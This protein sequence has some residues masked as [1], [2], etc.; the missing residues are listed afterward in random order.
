MVEMKKEKNKKPNILLSGGPVR[1]VG[2]GV[3]IVL[4]AAAAAAIVA[5]EE[6]NQRRRRHIAS[7]LTEHSLKIRRSTIVLSCSEV[8]MGIF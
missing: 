4:V 5:R 7:Y 1:P 3:V 6:K 2:Y 8:S